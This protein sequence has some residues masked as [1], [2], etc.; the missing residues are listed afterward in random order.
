MR[1]LMIGNSHTYANDLPL[2]V[3]TICRREGVHCDV[4]MIAKGGMG[5]G[6]HSTENLHEVRF[7]LLYGEYDV[8]ILQHK[9]HPFDSIDEMFEGGRALA[10]V[11]A[12]GK[13]P[14]KLMLYMPWS[15]K[16]NPEGQPTMSEAYRKLAG[17][18]AA[19]FIP[20]G[21]VWWKFS[22][23]HPELEM[24][25]R[26]GMHS[27]DLGAT[28]AAYVIFTAIT[29]RRA[30]PEDPIFADMARLAYEGVCGKV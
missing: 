23:L 24:Y 16:T 15:E 19:D 6:Y 7:N 1:L 20:V 3:R 4:T 21:E 9:A 30:T 22:R 28:L 29:K 8:A 5:F 11:N 27:S 26:D 25:S 12:D 17:E 14:P 2:K 18:M 13:N 10:K